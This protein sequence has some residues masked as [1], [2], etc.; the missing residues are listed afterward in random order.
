MTVFLLPGLYVGSRL[1][2]AF[3]AC[4]LDG[5]GVVDSLST[6]WDLTSEISLKTLGLL[7]LASLS[8]FALVI[9]L[10][11]V[12]SGVLFATGADLPA[13]PG[14]S[15]TEAADQFELTDYPALLVGASVSYAVSLA[16]VVG[17][18]QVAAARLYLR[19][20]YPDSEPTPR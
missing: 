11:I 1:F 14:V 16:I 8:V 17:A 6:S 4:V 10:S 18:V 19:L 7:V 20:R 3:P 9:V 5:E 13:E 15:P 12:T 2:L